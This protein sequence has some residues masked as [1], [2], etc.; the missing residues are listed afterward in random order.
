[1]ADFLAKLAGFKPT[2]PAMCAPADRPIV[3]ADLHACVTQGLVKL[4]KAISDG[5]VQA[6][7]LNTATEIQRHTDI[8]GPDCGLSISQQRIAR[9]EG[10]TS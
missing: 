4:F 1:M 10:M 6:A 2:P 8:I 3:Q 5:A 7:V 9:S